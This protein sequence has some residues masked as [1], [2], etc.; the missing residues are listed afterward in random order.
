LGPPSRASGWTRPGCTSWSG[1][2]AS[3]GARACGA[4]PRPAT[5]ACSWTD[6]GSDQHDATMLRGRSSVHPGA[7]L[8]APPR[9]QQRQ[10]PEAG[11]RT[12][13]EHRG[14]AASEV[15]RG[16]LHHGDDVPPEQELA[17]VAG[18]RLGAGLAH[19]E[20]GAEVAPDAIRR[21]PGPGELPHRHALAG[22]D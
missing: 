5:P 4:W 19:P 17:L 21:V 7:L 13:V 12:D 11:V 10:R 1:P 6:L 15:L 3:S 20:L 22:P 14:L 16:E 2:P 8:G 9:V 18:L